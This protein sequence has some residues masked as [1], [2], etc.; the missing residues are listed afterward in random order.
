MSVRV[1]WDR[2]RESAVA[3]GLA[4]TALRTGSALLVLPLVLRRLPPQELGIWYA[5][6]AIAAGAALVDFGFGPSFS[7]LAAYLRAGATELRTTGLAPGTP[8]APP[9]WE[10]LRR[11][12]STSAVLYAAITAL[13]MLV[14]VAIAQVVL[15]PEIAKL[16]DPRD[17]VT[18]TLIFL[19]AAA[20]GMYGA[21]FSNLLTGLGQVAAALRINVAAQLA[22]LLASFGALLLGYGLSG[23]AGAAL[24]ATLLNVFSLRARLGREF[25]GG[26]GA[27]FSWEYF[28]AMVPTTARIGAVVAGTYLITQANTLVATS[29]LGAARTASYGLS[30]QAITFVT[31]SAFVFVSTKIPMLAHLRQQGDIPRLRVVFVQAMR[32]SLALFAVLAAALFLVGPAALAWVGAR[33]ELLPISQLA[34][35]LAVRLLES[36][37]SVHGAI[38]VTE[39]KVP[40]VA[41]ALV[42][43]LAVVVFS[44][45]LARPW[46]MWAIIVVPGVVQAAWN[47]W[48]TVLRCLHGIDLRATAYFRGLLFGPRGAV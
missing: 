45:A 30:L 3:W 29:A 20:V 15:R 8:G 34:L 19:V 22:T 4:S 36:H 13:A 46:G 28:R 39:N 37:H 16:T 17:A 18:G 43:G 7:R 38:I 27:G 1:L 14:F 6:Q 26:H 24:L 33:T 40:F 42:S 5:L 35:L 32:R 47:N 25:A 23:L 21:H 44:A 48:W 2:A 31:S 12:R 41:A 9:N 10:G 11:L